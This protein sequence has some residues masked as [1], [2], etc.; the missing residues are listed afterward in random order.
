[1]GAS[2]ALWSCGCGLQALHS[3]K[4]VQRLSLKQHLTASRALAPALDQ[5]HPPVRIGCRRFAC[6]RFPRRWIRLA[7]VVAHSVSVGLAGA[8]AGRDRFKP[9]MWLQV[10][11]DVIDPP[12]VHR[13]M[14]ESEKQTSPKN[15]KRTPDHSITVE[16]QKLESYG[17]GIPSA[18][19]TKFVS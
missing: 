8:D 5:R 17:L 11:D 16:I 14:R 3:R 12:G 7:E 2:H 9:E 1:M 4:S 15:V 18:V 13:M 10:G 19:P 6:G